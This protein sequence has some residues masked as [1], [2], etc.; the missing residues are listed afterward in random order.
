VPDDLV[1][2]GDPDRIVDPELGREAPDA[3]LGTGVDR[4]AHDRRALLLQLGLKLDELRDLSPAGRA[5]GP[6]EV[7]DHDPAAVIH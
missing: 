3:L 5:P 1:R 4:D 7:E 2:P 6:P